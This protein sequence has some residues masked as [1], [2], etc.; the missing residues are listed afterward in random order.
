LFN[1]CL[2][3]KF[4]NTRRLSAVVRANE[5]TR[6]RQENAVPQLTSKTTFARRLFLH[7]LGIT[8][9]AATTAPL[10][11]NNTRADSETRDEKRKGRYQESDHVKT[12]YRVNAYPR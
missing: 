12:F 4:V 8:A 11:I 3:G 9:A 5:R 1:T 10:V 2:G 6:N 7:A